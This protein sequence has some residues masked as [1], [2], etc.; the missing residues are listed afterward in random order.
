MEDWE[1]LTKT[2]RKVV[3]LVAEGLTNAEIAARQFVSVRTVE[4]HIANI[5]A[6]LGIPSRRQLAREAARSRGR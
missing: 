4:T 1:R 6:K 5:L 3:A 2:E